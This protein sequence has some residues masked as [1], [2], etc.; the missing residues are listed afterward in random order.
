MSEHLPENLIGSQIQAP[1][2]TCN[3]H[4]WH[5]VDRVAVGSHAGKIGP[6]LEHGP[7]GDAA[8]RNKKQA[9][10]LRR[11]QQQQRQP[12]LFRGKS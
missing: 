5:R 3:R 10:Q 4:T 1:C 6:C 8:G 7:K 12:N 2:S 11:R 9:N